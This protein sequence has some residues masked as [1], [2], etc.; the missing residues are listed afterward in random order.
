[1]HWGN[2]AVTGASAMHAQLFTVLRWIHVLRARRFHAISDY[3]S[4]E[5]H[6]FLQ[7]LASSVHPLPMTR[8][9]ACCANARGRQRG[10]YSALVP[11]WPERRTRDL[12]APVRIRLPAGL[13]QGEDAATPG[14]HAYRTA[15]RRR[16][17]RFTYPEVRSRRAPQ[18][19]ARAAGVPQ[20]QP[21]RVFAVVPQTT[22]VDPLCAA[23]ER[24]TRG[25]V[26][27]DISTSRILSARYEFDGVPALALVVAVA[28]EGVG[29]NERRRKR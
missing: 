21:R 9:T 1:M 14:Q 19:S 20:Y 10:T 5:E 26:L 6:R 18:A 22:F 28:E 2:L 27:F 25:D 12:R 13:P 11:A 29:R 4:L 23:A 8:S 7:S 17:A 16:Q 3:N 24:S 15:L